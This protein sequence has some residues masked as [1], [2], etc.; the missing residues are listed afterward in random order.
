M[1]RAM[2]HLWSTAA[3]LSAIVVLS[4]CIPTT[5][6]CADVGFTALVVT[7]R[8]Q[9]GTPQALGATLTLYDG[10]YSESDSNMGNDSLRI[11]GA[12]NRGNHSYD[13]KVSKPYYNDGWVR[14]VYAPGTGCVNI[15]VG[16]MTTT[17]PVT[18]SLAA[19][20]PGVRS[21]FVLPS[22]L[23][24][25]RAPYLSALV[26][27]PYL[28]HDPGVSKAVT[29]RITGD[30]ASVT[31]DTTRGAVFYRCLKTSG[32]LTVTAR[33][34]VDSTV[35]GSAT[36]QVQGHPAATDDPPCG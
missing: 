26:F 16:P 17:V 34:V 8:D 22:H 4:T 7:V 24:L 32:Y 15:G 21:L 5:K 10:T 3:L 19:G 12:G 9:L 1:R 6:D 18:I 28:D 33:S 31:F 25:D 2:R 36:I 30:T 14:D 13:V 11:G 35:V 27:T 20:A 23:N 29:W